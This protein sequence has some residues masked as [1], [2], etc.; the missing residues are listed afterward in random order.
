M[1]I[2]S[3]GRRP[4]ALPGG[5]TRVALEDGDEITL[6]ATAHAPGYVSIGFGPCLGMVASVL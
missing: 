1:E 6:A 4:C 5:E 2:A 3:G